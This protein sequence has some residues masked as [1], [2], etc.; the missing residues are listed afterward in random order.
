VFL[1]EL[2]VVLFNFLHVLGISL[3]EAAKSLLPCGVLPRKSVKGKI[4]LITGAGSGLGR[5]C[6]VE[7]GKL[8]AHLVLW[9][10]DERGNAETKAMIGESVEVHIYKVDLSSRAQIYETAERVK[11]E[12][13]EVEILFN[14]AGI[15]SGKRLFDCPDELIERTMAVNTNA[16]FYTA[17]AF[18]PSMLEKNSGHIVTTAS[19]AGH[20]GVAGLVDYCSSKHAAVGFSESIRAELQRTGKDGVHVTTICPFYVNTGMFN[21]IK[22][23]SPWW[24]P[25]LEQ[26]YAVGRIVEAVL[27]NAENLVMPKTCNL[28]LLLKGILPSRALWIL[29][30]YFCLNLTMDD[31]V[32]RELKT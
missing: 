11:R 20:F 30:D 23:K 7:F 10:I 26:D 22:C 12:V 14:N 17:K 1:R 27:T 29:A 32:G 21:G 25:I 9:D 5:H 28:V 4:M 19:M 2:P 18:V 24:F 31:Y 6:A 15:V 8:G 13:G 16:L 3:I